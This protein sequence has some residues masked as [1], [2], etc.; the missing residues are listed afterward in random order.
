MHLKVI[1]REHTQ[2]TQCSIK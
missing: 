1:I 2:P